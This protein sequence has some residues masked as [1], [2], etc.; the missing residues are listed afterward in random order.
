MTLESHLQLS[1]MQKMKCDL[2][3]RFSRSRIP[4]WFFSVFFS[5]SVHQITWESTLK[6]SLLLEMKFDL[7]IQI[8]KINNFD[9]LYSY[10][11]SNSQKS[12]Y[13]IVYCITRDERQPLQRVWIFPPKRSEDCSHTSCI[14]CILFR[15]MHII[16]HSASF[17]NPIFG[18]C[19][20]G[21]NYDFQ[22]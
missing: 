4:Q 5:Y 9:P 18:T 10:L 7:G 14:R 12:C 22:P 16:F 13:E 2:D 19:R 8:F 15:V 21:W 1:I 20:A 3:C 11:K 17:E 6:S